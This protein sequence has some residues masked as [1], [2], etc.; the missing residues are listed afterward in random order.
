MSLRTSPQTGVAISSDFGDSHVAP[1]LAMTQKIQAV[2][3]PCEKLSKKEKRKIHQTRQQ[4]WG[5][6]NPI[7]GQ[8][9]N[10]KVYNRNKSRI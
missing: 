10:S 6:L 9:K 1:L 3:Y 7:T 8:P 4:T 5:E 2:A